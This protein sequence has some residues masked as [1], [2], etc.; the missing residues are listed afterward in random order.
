[1][2]KVQLERIT[3]VERSAR[4]DHNQVI[5]AS[6]LLTDESIT[7]RDLARLY[8]RSARQKQN[9]KPYLKVFHC[10]NFFASN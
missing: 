10:F 1:M 5:S 2:F 9:N 3:R 4:L 8:V 7:E 6:F